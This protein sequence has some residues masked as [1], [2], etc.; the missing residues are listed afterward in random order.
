MISA[1]QLK[2]ILQ[3]AFTGSN[4]LGYTIP[5]VTF[6]ANPLEYDTGALPSNI[7]LTG[8][9]IPNGRTGISWG[10]Y[11]NTNT[12]PIVTGTALT[13]NFTDITPFA[14][15]GVSTYKL[16]VNYNAPNNTPAPTI[17]KTIN[18]S[19][20][21]QAFVGQL[22]GPSVVLASAGDLIS[23]SPSIL[24]TLS[25]KSKTQ[26]INPFYMDL[27]NSA[28]LVF[29]IPNNY[30]TVANIMDNTDQNVLSSFTAIPDSSNQRTIYV[31]NNLTT[32]ST[33]R[34]QFVF[35]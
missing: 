16:V 31:S 3:N 17:T 21:T 28:K 29:V 9:I 8:S 13:I 33:V 15:P 5:E 27:Q 35:N 19:V 6:N 25:S 11:E 7:I 23:G 2:N 1:K 30:G 20:T 24:S 4:A 26:I 14:T 10:I 22:S 12:T 18:I 34:Y 32:P